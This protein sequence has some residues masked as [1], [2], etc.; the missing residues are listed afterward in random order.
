[1]PEPGETPHGPGGQRTGVSARTPARERVR[2][3]RGRG[4]PRNRGMERKGGIM[5]EAIR[6][7]LVA[8]GAG[9][10]SATALSSA[11]CVLA[12]CPPLWRAVACLTY[13]CSKKRTEPPGPESVRVR[14]QCLRLRFGSVRI[15]S[16]VYYKLVQFVGA[17]SILDLIPSCVN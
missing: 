12:K 3:V 11:L 10:W 6:R 14:L 4:L 15:G 8:G 7:L 1:M 9:E 2:R 13:T 5:V 17:T 16:V